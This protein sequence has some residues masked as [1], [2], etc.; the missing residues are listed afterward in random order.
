M[1][2]VS[3]KLN[4]LAIAIDVGIGVVD[5]IEKGTY[6]RIIPDATVDMAVTAGVIGCGT[7]AKAAVTAAA[8]YELPNGKTVRQEIKDV[9]Y[10]GAKK[11]GELLDEGAK[12]IGGWLG[13]AFGW[14]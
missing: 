6:D 8:N 4:A 13:D 1:E 3:N 9:Y 5:N 11:A 7:L 14:G 12:K 10:E 2:K